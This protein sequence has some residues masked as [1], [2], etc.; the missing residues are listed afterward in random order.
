MKTT[1]SPAF[2][3][4]LQR[5]YELGQCIGT[6]GFSTVHLAIHL[7]SFQKVA[8]KT[9]SKSALSASSQAHI[10]EEIALLRRIKHASCVGLR[11]VVGTSS[12]LYLV[13]E[14]AGGGNLFRLVKANGPRSE[15]EAR[16]LFLDIAKAVAYCH[17]QGIY[18]RDIKPENVVLTKDGKAKLTDFGFATTA[19]ESTAQ[20]GTPAYMSPELLQRLPSTCAKSDIW[21]LGVLLHFMLTGYRPRYREAV[22]RVQ[23][24]GMV[25]LSPIVKV[26]LARLLA[27]EQERRP[28]A[29]EVLAYAWLREE[30]ELPLA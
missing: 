8:I 10:S 11:E 13:M 2:P 30:L 7:N 22:R 25:R 17:S 26:L 5:D 27:V 6:G 21:G 20:V 3:L 18:H 15:E 14:Y 1:Q 29:E 28:A 16:D 9:Y 23:I 12:H 24:R 4:C 19:K